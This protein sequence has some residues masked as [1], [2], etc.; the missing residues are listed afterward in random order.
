[1]DGLFRPLVYFRV[2]VGYDDFKWRNIEISN[3]QMAELLNVEAVFLPNKKGEMVA[4]S[5]SGD[6]FTAAGIVEMVTQAMT[7]TAD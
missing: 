7:N 6:F 1:M 3:G 2:P 4:F 5:W